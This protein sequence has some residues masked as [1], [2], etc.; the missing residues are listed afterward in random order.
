[1]LKAISVPEGP[2]KVGSISLSKTDMSRPSRIG[3]KVMGRKLFVKI[4]YPAMPA[5]EAAYPER[6][7]QQLQ[8]RKDLPLI[9][10]GVIRYQNRYQTHTFSSLDSAETNDTPRVVIYSHGLISFAS[11]S[12]HLMEH[13]ASH[14]Y[15]A[16]AVEHEEQLQELTGLR[17]KTSK[18]QRKEDA[19]LS[20]SIQQASGVS[21]AELSR[22]YYSK[23]ENTNQIT[24]QRS[25][26]IAYLTEHLDEL[27]QSIPNWRS[28]VPR[29]LPV[30]LAGQSLGGAVA[31]EFTKFHDRSVG[32]VNIYG[33]MYGTQT[34]VPIYVPY[35]MMYS[36]DNTSSNADYIRDSAEHRHICVTVPETKHL[37]FHELTM[38]LGFL[39]WLKQTGK[40]RPQAVIA[41][42]N[43]R[44]LEFLNSLDWDQ[45]EQDQVICT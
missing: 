38:N 18:E 37:N 26:D 19:Q 43:K 15:I 21:K 29:K 36:Q 41:Y 28:E 5:K 9:M 22:T 16:I 25:S 14:G 12:T 4:W 32:V 13:L 33:G 8:G 1:M 10:R 27:L 40:A 45:N 35:L 11:E 3:S 42:K 7:W 30:A 31:T 34:S 2:Y 24:S 39:R 20:A 23:A 17:Q 44:I 6:L